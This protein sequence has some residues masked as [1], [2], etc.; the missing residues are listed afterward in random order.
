MQHLGIESAHWVGTSMGGI[1]GMMMAAGFPALITKLVLNDIGSLIP[2]AGL[3]RIVKYVSD[4]ESFTT[5]E[6]AK[7]F[8]YDIFKPFGIEEKEHWEYMFEHSVITH[9]DGGF[10]LA[11]DPKII[12]N[13][14]I[15]TQNF[16]QIEDVDL[17]SIWNEVHCPTLLIRGKYSDLLLEETMHSMATQAHVEHIT[18]DHCGHAP[19]LFT[20]KR[21]YDVIEF[22]SKE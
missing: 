3:E 15:N 11:Y 7:H 10:M 6:A 17:S 5:M 16:S 19:A 20:N 4:S 18:Y 13:F 22:L 9:P 12:E 21:I 14:R 2:K 8:M 1:I